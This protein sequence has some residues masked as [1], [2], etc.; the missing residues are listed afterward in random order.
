MIGCS[1]EREYSVKLDNL[2][3]KKKCNFTKKLCFGKNVDAK[4]NILT[5]WEKIMKYR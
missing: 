1:S 4:V 2:I 3:K 5:K